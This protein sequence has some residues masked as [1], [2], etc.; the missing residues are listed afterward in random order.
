GAAISRPSSTAV[1]RAGG[2]SRRRA[3]RSGWDDG[4]GA[5]RPSALS[6]AF[7]VIFAAFFSPGRKDIVFLPRKALQA[8]SA[9]GRAP[10]QL[11]G[12]GGRRMP[13]RARGRRG[14]RRRKR[15]GARRY[16]LQAQEGQLPIAV[17]Q[18]RAAEGDQA[19]EAES[20]QEGNL[21]PVSHEVQEGGADRHMED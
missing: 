15:G 1:P 6:G 8:G 21:V 14:R 5:S 13:L 10:T 20:Q 17:A 7:E 16:L 4:R 9:P 3:E 2:R 12:G 11:A 18:M 19:E